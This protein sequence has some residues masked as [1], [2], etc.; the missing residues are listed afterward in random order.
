[1][2][3]FE[4][5]LMEALKSYGKERKR[6]VDLSFLKAVQSKYAE[7]LNA[8]KSAYSV[9]VN[10]LYQE[11]LLTCRE[12]ERRWVK[13][14]ELALYYRTLNNIKK[15]D[16]KAIFSQRLYKVLGPSWWNCQDHIVFEVDML[17]EGAFAIPE[18]VYLL[19]KKLVKDPLFGIDLTGDEHKAAVI[20]ALRELR[21]LF[22]PKVIRWD[23]PTD[24]VKFE[25]YERLPPQLD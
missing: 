5:S 12:F 2:D 9:P 1:M 15:H 17:C 14:R 24:F 13:K 21:E 3:N 11:K 25:K 4:S 23:L 19:Y 10:L 18:N 22:P 16:M 8:E 20:G 6:I 7:R